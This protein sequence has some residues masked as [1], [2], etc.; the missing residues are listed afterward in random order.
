M[1]AKTTTLEEVTGIE[2]EKMKEFFVAQPKCPDSC[3]SKTQPR[4]ESVDSGVRH[5]WCR[6]CGCEWLEHLS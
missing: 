6:G 3:D 5:M 2:L 1:A 4:V